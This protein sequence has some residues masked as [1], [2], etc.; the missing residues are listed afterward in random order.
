MQRVISDNGSPIASPISQMQQILSDD[1]TA[2]FR[3]ERNIKV[4][5]FSPYPPGASFLGGM[6]E[7][8]VK[9]VKH[10]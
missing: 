4:L 2:N 7:S 1:E 10:V 6:V 8:L 9:Q 5:V 3:K